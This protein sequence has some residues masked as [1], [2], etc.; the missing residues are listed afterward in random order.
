MGKHP[1]VGVWEVHAPAAPFPHHLMTFHADGTVL[2]A[3]PDGARPE[4]SDSPGM[5]MWQPDPHQ[6]GAVIGRF[7]EISVARSTR[8]FLGRTSVAFQITVTGDTFTGAATTVCPG[9]DDRTGESHTPLHA[10]R[11]TPSS[12][13]PPGTPP[14]TPPGA[15]AQ[16]ESGRDL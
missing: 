12:V 6:P 7:V 15:A 14:G 13:R 8:E 4:V 3:N 9:S 2:Q 5:G 10:I 11:V 16:P 1:V